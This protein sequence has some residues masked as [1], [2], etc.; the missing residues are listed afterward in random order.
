MMTPL[1]DTCPPGISKR[2]W[3]NW[4]TKAR[5]TAL[6]QYWHALRMETQNMLALKYGVQRPTPPFLKG[7]QHG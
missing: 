7:G 5:H 1:P 2:T 6:S 3:A 4:T